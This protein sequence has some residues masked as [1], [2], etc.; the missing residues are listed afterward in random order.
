MKTTDEDFMDFFSET[1]NVQFVEVE[2]EGW[3]NIY[4][5]TIAENAREDIERQ[6]GKVISSGNAKSLG[7]QGNK[8]VDQKGAKCVELN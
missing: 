7:I 5:G 4:R 1:Y 3:A 8:T 6:G 2:A